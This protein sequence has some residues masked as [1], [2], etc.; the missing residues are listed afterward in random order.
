M[1]ATL[2]HRPVREPL[3]IPAAISWSRTLSTGNRVLSA[4]IDTAPGRITGRA[5][6]LAYRDGIRALRLDV[7]EDARRAFETAA[8]QLERY[9][10]DE[11]SPHSP[12]LALFAVDGQEHAI[13]VRLPRRPVEH[14]RWDDK[15]EIAP[16]EALQDEYERIAVVLFDAQHTRVFTIF[17]GA[18]ETVQAFEDD[19]PA[20]QSTGGWYSLQQSKIARH[21][22]DHL[23][24]HAERTVRTLMEALRSRSFDHLLLAGPDEPLAILRH[25]LTPPLRARV[26]GTL[27]LEV[28]ATD[29]QVLAAT[30][31]K[32]DQIQQ[33]DQQRLVDELLDSAATP[34]VVLG[35][36]GTLDAIAEGRVHLLALSESFADSGA[37]C[38]ACDRL[39][40]DAHRCPACGS[41]TRPQENLREIIVQ[42]ALMQAARL[43]MVSG[44][45][46]ARLDQFG[47]IG[48]WTRF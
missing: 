15:P 35:L 21:R 6:L 19:V 16:L 9:L 3:D 7:P 29:A 5:Y 46:A 27:D 11:F 45:A 48:A 4:Y 17:L 31:L 40:K 37:Q 24:W 41:Q 42:Q 18:V 14:V 26:A 36:A 34:H 2:T 8:A 43:E 44:A 13:A 38:S 10:L 23:R 32:A 47:G 33:Q 22:E 39:V 12:G 28:F 20:K 25:E 1:S 30:L